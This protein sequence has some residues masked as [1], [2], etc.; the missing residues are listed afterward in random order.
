[1][2]MNK[3][4]IAYT[5]WLK[6]LHFQI[7]WRPWKGCPVGALL[8]SALT[9]APINFVSSTIFRPVCAVVFA[10]NV[11]KQFKTSRFIDIFIDNFKKGYNNSVLVFRITNQV[12]FLKNT[13]VH[14]SR[15][16]KKIKRATL[17]SLA[18]PLQ[19]FQTDKYVIRYKYPHQ[20]IEQC[21]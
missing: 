17:E 15:Q 1:M 6:H 5:C 12:S 2:I 4:L 21:N 10:L 11:V 19:G 16:G 7:L 9:V 8:R 18:S 14:I 3:S 13:W 20:Q